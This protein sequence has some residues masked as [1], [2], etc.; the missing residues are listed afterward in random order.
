MRPLSGLTWPPALVR[1]TDQDGRLQRTKGRT[2]EN[3]PWACKS[4]VGP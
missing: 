2:G 3:G 1:Q 4:T